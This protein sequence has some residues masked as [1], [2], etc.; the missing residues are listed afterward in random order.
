MANA[1][2]LTFMLL[3]WRG[4]KDTKIEE[5]HHHKTT[6]VVCRELNDLNDGSQGWFS[7]INR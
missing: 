7:D 5:Y 4:W 3:G 6:A 1:A 2:T